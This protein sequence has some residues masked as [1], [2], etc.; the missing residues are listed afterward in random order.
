[1]TSECLKIKAL[2]I[3]KCQKFI[4]QL[5][6]FQVL[7]IKKKSWNFFEVGVPKYL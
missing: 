1:M 5:R 4:L 6:R 2:E 7:K 3:K